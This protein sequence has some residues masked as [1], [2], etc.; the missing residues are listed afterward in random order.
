[1]GAA[2]ELGNAS[3][4]FARTAGKGLRRHEINRIVD[5]GSI[6]NYLHGGH[7]AWT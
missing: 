2:S 4:W 5:V 3:R 1:M 7:D 6:F